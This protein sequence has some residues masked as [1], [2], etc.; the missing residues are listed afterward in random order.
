MAG[1]ALYS[2]N[3]PQTLVRSWDGFKD[4]LLKAN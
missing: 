4:S 2:S 1:D 3:A